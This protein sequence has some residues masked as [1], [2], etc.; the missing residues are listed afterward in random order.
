MPPH[1]HLPLRVLRQTLLIYCLSR[2]TPR[3]TSGKGR[4]FPRVHLSCLFLLER[5]KKFPSG[6]YK[7][8]TRAQS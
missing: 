7:G 6:V 8:R 1:L 2:N 4:Q 3:L 5:V